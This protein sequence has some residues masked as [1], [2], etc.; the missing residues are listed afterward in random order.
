MSGGCDFSV[1]DVDDRTSGGCDFSVVDVDDRMSGGCD[2]SV[3]DVDDT[4][5]VVGVI[6]VWWML[7]TG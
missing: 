1:V 3:V 2:F 6:S 4:G 5:R 7:M